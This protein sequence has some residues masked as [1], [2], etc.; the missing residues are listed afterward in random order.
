[1]SVSTCMPRHAY[2]GQRTIAWIH[3]STS[4]FY[5]APEKELK[6][7]GFCSNR[8]SLMHHLA[9]PIFA[10]SFIPSDLDFIFIL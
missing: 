5:I 4:T 7:P 8:F 10:L 6:L 3:F 9:R 2:G 1:M